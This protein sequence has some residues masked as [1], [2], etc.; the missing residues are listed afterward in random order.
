MQGAQVQSLVRELRSHMLHSR[1]KKINN[2]LKKKE[3][4]EKTKN[5]NG[6]GKIKDIRVN[7][8]LWHLQL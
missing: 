1:A 4:S 5:N 2:R 7:C 8:S 6:R 3:L